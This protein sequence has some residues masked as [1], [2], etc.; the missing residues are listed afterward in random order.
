[1]AWNTVA[2]MWMP[3]RWTQ[4]SRLIHSLLKWGRNRTTRWKTPWKNS[5]RL[6]PRQKCKVFRLGEIVLLSAMRARCSARKKPNRELPAPSMNR[7]S[8]VAHYPSLCVPA[9]R[10]SRPSEQ[11]RRPMGN[12]H[13]VLEM[14]RKAAVSGAY[15]PAVRLQLRAALAGGHNRFNGNDQPFG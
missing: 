5:G 6:R 8:K 2:L 7:Q 14:G 9:S 3:L 10:L 15:S 12:H 4:S 11:Q 1:M 13:G